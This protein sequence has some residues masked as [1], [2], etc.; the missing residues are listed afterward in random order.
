M[1]EL[2]SF[3]IKKILKRKKN[4]IFLICLLLITLVIGYKLN[5][6]NNMAESTEK[7]QCEFQMEF[8]ENEK[9]KEELINLYREKL[10]AFDEKSWK[11]KIE[12]QIKIDQYFLDNNISEY[13]SLDMIYAR[14]EKNK[15]LLKENIEPIYENYNM[16]SYNFLVIFNRNIFP[17]FIMIFILLISSDIVSIEKQEGTYKFML[18]QPYSRK[19]VI[20]AKIIGATI[21]A[22]SVLF[23]I[24]LFGFL[25]L[26]LING[27]GNPMYPMKFYD[28][29][30]KSFKFIG[31]RKF[32][33]ILFMMN[34][35]IVLFLVSVGVLISNI[36]KD[37]LSC[38]SFAM[39]LG[40]VIFMVNIRTLRP[41]K[42]MYLNPFTYIPAIYTLS[43]LYV[44][45]IS[46]V[47]IQYF[48]IIII[49]STI[50][51]YILSIYLFSKEDII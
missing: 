19:K 6:S 4:I 35:L 2:I 41:Y 24:L 43:G 36:F 21:V 5:K 33:F 8:F 9:G 26:G 34:F 17:I 11:E 45:L 47:N 39:I 16:S 15:E 22:L 25:I 38:V 28:L 20:I 32:A 3:E 10:D 37:S 13:E 42:L 46:K 30:D 14:L 18:L 40:V 49:L 29:A 7:L 44:N 48:F 12:I 1:K 51:N 31:I 23:I 27:F 50:F